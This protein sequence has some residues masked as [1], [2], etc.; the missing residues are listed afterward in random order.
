[1]G[2]TGK[3]VNQNTGEILKNAYISTYTT[4]IQFRKL[5]DQEERRLYFE[6]KEELPPNYLE[7]GGYGCIG[8]YE[9]QG[10]LNVFYNR[11]ARNEN[12][13][14]ITKLFFQ[15]CVAQPNDFHKHIYTY[16]KKKYPTLVNSD[17]EPVVEEVIEE[18]QT[19][20]VVE[21]EPNPEYLKMMEGVELVS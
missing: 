10:H 3:F 6:G 13:E 19:E 16:I 7:A 17:S 15:V 1:M 12:K 18:P 11:K 8:R 14:P 9:C 2:L 20:T 4:N 5:H 21:E